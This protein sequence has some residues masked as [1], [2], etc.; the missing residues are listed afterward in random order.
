VLSPELKIGIAAAIGLIVWAIV[1]AFRAWISKAPSPDPWGAEIARALDGPDATP[2]CP[3]C[4]C[5]QEPTR[6]FCA[7]CGRS[8]GDYNN[9]NPY[10]YIFSLGEVLREGTSGHIRKSWLTVSG[11]V[12][13]SLIEYTVLA[14]IYWFQLIRNLSRHS[15][16]QSL[17]DDPPV[18]PRG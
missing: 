16:P 17:N 15:R 11:F 4:Q 18:I 12:V 14:P 1:R 9:I 5:P 3:H 6:W 10:L 13:L 2:V 7:E 8:V